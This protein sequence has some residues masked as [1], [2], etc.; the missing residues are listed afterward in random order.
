MEQKQNHLASILSPES[1]KL[2]EKT[3]LL[4]GRTKILTQSGA[5]QMLTI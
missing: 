2:T 4:L 1:Y 5:S 3:E